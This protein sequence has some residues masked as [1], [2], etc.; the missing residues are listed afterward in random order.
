MV[1]LGATEIVPPEYGR[2]Y[3]IPLDPVTWIEAALVSVTFRV[4]LCPEEMLLELAVIETVGAAA[5]A[6]GAK[7]EIETKARRTAGKGP[8]DFI[9]SH[10]VHSSRFALWREFSPI[11]KSP[12]RPK[13]WTGTNAFDAAFVEKGSNPYRCTV[14]TSAPHQQF[15]ARE[16]PGE[17]PGV[18]RARS[19]PQQLVPTSRRDLDG[20][21][22]QEE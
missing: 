10:D 19:H 5:L 9:S 21:P 17:N 20:H 12:P 15:Q 11:G 2:L 14:V 1:E 6:L 8:K 13:G 4:M 18:C 7:V 22:S 3:E 16:N